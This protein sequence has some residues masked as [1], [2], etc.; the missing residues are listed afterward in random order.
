[1]HIQI[2]IIAN[3]PGLRETAKKRQRIA[4]EHLDT[5]QKRSKTEDAERKQEKEADCLHL[6]RL[7]DKSKD[8]TY[9]W[10][11][12]RVEDRVEGTCTWFLQHPHFL[13]WVEQDS[14]PLLVSA[15]PGCGKSV[16]TKYLVDHVLPGSGTV[17]YFFFKDRDQNTVR[18]A[19]CALL[20]QLIS[21]KPALIQHAMKQ[22]EKDGQG[23]IYSTN[24]LWTILQDAVQDEQAGSVIILLDAL[25]ECL[26]TE[27]ENLMRNIKTQSLKHQSSHKRIRYLM[28]SRPYEQIVA[29]FRGLLNSFPRIH[30]PGEEKF[31]AIG[32]EVNHVIKYRVERL[33]EEMKL[34]NEV[35]NHLTDR[36]IRTEHRTYLWVYLVFDHIETEGFKKTKKGIEEATKSLPRTVNEAYE[37]ILAKSGGDQAT[38]RRALA[39]ILAASRPL[40]LA[41]LNLALEVKET[42]RSTQDLDL[43]EENNFKSRLRSWCGLFVSVHHGKVY[44]LHQTAREFLLADPLHFTPISQGM[45]WRHSITIQDAHRVLAECCVRYLSFLNSDASLLADLADWR[46]NCRPRKALV[47]Y[48]AHFWPMHFRESCF[49]SN[50][51][52]AISLLALSVSNPNSS[53]FSQWGRKYWKQDDLERSSQLVI[54]SLLGHD[55][56]VQLLLDKDANV[57]A[58][59]E[60]HGNALLAASAYGHN[61]V[62]KLL[63]DKGANVNAKHKK[64]SNALYIASAEGYEQ[65]VEMLLDRGA[66]FNAQD[67][68]FGS[69]LQAA[70]CEGHDQVV[71]ILLDR[72]ADVNAQGGEYCSNALYEASIRGYEQVV[73]ILLDRGADVNAQGGEERG[74]ALEAA[75]LEGHIQ[76]VKILLDKGA[77]VNAQSEYYGKVLQIAS[78]GGYEQVVKIMLDRGAEVNAQGGRYYSSALHAASAGGH[79]RVVKMLLER[80]ADVNAQG[81]WYSDAL[82]EALDNGHEQIVELLFSHGACWDWENISFSSSSPSS[83]SSSS[84]PSSPSSSS[85]S[86]F[87]SSFSSSSPSS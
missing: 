24:S 74:S 34:T 28:T 77:D 42:T 3:L 68:Y 4:E 7:T 5:V 1:L 60:I 8:A 69:A 14:G 78:V 39:M 2:L 37:Q 56:V 82:Q 66:D 71:R 61:R 13:E 52:T 55:T 23:L 54:S 38:V 21:K 25:D 35:K 15:D 29:K 67:G 9:E 6:F 12:S 30:I 17:C 36:L 70:S 44:F 48:S 76:V 51:N 65:V 75:L 59:D 10:Y 73:R 80:G 79:E 20:H 57:D 85:S 50:R 27:L 49:C 63:L 31:E 11:K 19:L 46:V 43:E 16:L 18:Q 81:E 72:G 53:S 26:E 64:Y 40:T 62:V 33:A 84:F 83:P 22:Y 32:Q 41:E 58:Q 87:S 86:S 45:Q 47:D